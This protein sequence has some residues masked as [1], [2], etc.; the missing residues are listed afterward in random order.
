MRLKTATAL[1]SRHAAQI[2]NSYYLVK[3]PEGMRGIQI[4]IRPPMHLYIR[5]LIYE[6][7]SKN[8]VDR[9]VKYLRRLNWDDPE[10]SNYTIRCLS[11]AYL[12]RYHIIRCLADVVSALSSYQE[13]AVT[14]VKIP[15]FVSCYIAC[16]CNV[17]C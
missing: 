2:E 3:P 9:I 13:K 17:S 7:L 16:K 5:H 6:E 11:R 4:K 12:L 8:N 15:K 14:K 1:D 10:I